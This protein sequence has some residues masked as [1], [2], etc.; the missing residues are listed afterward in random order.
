MRVALDA[1]PLIGPRTGVGHYVAGLV[2]GLLGLAEPPEVTLTA[3]TFRGRKDLHA[4]PGARVAARPAPAR[5]LQA[6]W[7]RGS[8][9][10]VELLS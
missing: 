1:T 9:P 10:P 2:D 8:F 7:L 5:L 3:F 6:A 4:P